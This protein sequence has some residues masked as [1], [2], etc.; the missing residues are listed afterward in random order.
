MALTKR[1]TNRAR[2]EEVARGVIADATDK[3]L[4]V[5]LDEHKVGQYAFP[6]PGVT[7]STLGSTWACNVFQKLNSWSAYLDN[8][9]TQGTFCLFGAPRR[10]ASPFE[11]LQQKKG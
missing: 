7:K 6:T 3:L 2:L 10:F 8:G 11:K 4:E 9:D 5:G 1:I